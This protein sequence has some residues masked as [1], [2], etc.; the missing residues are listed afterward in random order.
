MECF[1]D[2]IKACTYW[3]ASATYAITVQSE[4]CTLSYDLGRDGCRN[5]I[6]PKNSLFFAYTRTLHKL[7]SFPKSLTNFG[8]AYMSS[9]SSAG[10]PSRTNTTR[11]SSSSSSSVA[12]GR[13][14][15][16]RDP[17]GRLQGQSGGSAASSSG[18]VP[19]SLSPSGPRIAVPSSEPVGPLFKNDRNT[20]HI[21][22]VEGHGLLPSRERQ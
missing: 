14:T 7:P 9:S 18:T 4:F 3:R 17:S 11:R 19:S 2:R 5:T 1:P 10:Q 22:F 20:I 13:S 6:K 8:L 21:R 16:Q 15:P 12:T